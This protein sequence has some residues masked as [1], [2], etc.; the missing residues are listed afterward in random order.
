MISLNFTI[1]HGG[2]N[3]GLEIMRK[4]MTDAA[5]LNDDGWIKGRKPTF[6]VGMEGAGATEH[7]RL[8]EAGRGHKEEA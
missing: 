3:G 1:Y 8:P 2:K 7:S 6:G 5:G 4:P